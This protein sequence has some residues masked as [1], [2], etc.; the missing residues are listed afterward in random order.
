VRRVVFAVFAGFL[1]FPLAAFAAN[2]PDFSG[3]WKMDPS[4]SESAHQDVPIGPVVLVI[5]QTAGQF[6]VE[7]RRRQSKSSA[8]SSEV[9]TFELDGKETTNAENADMP[10]KVKAHWDGS[11]L[12]AETE[13]DINGSTVTTMQVFQLAAN[14][15][16]ITI[17]KTLTVH[18]GYQGPGTE[19]VTG[20]GR[21][22]F[23]KTTYSTPAAKTSNGPQ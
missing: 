14:G 7:T 20:T 6:S 22:V 18:H 3:T 5:Q 11:K 10:I 4:R 12:V 8:I 19:K 13:R 2:K 9:L 16:E 23:I 21:D 1:V 17:E 15:K